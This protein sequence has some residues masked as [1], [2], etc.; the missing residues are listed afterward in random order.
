MN[1]FTDTEQMQEASNEFSAI[2]NDLRDLAVNLNNLI[3]Y[4]EPTW[5]GNAGTAYISQ[6]RQ[7]LTEINRLMQ[8]VQVM[9]NTAD[10]RI[11]TT[12]SLDKL[13]SLNINN[14]ISI[15]GDT[16]SSGLTLL[17]SLIQ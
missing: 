5:T 13:E 15:I 10:E 11:R 4:L 9:K 1:I 6:L 14:V 2:L 7:Q 17:A 8:M 12:I 3:N 16:F